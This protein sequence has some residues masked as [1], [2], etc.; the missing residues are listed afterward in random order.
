M[1]PDLNEK[2]R[3]PATKN[4]EFGIAGGIELEDAKSRRSD[5]IKVY[6]NPD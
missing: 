2:S 3:D 5:T 4:L 1:K 6:L